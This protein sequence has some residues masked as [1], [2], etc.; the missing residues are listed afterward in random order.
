MSAV[1]SNPSRREFL[2]AAA[3]AG[4]GLLIGFSMPGRRL[5]AAEPGSAPFHPNAFIR[6]AADDSV[7]LIVSMAEMGQGVLTSLPQLLAEELE[8]DWHRVRVE[9]APVDPA[10]N[11]PI[12]GLQ[13]TGGSTS[14]RAFWDP[15]RRAGASARE[16][17]IT[18]AATSWGVD[19][20]T[21]HAREGAV[22][23]A[24]GKQLSYG[25]LAARASQLPVPTDVALKDPKDFKILGRPLQ[26]L[27]SPGKV[28][29]SAR[30]GL[31]VR[32][33]GLLTAVIARP[34]A[35]GAKVTGFDASRAKAVSGVKHVV[36]V[37]SGVAVVAD[38]FWAAK[39]GRDALDVQWDLGASS[40]LSSKGI[41]EA[42]L[43]RLKTSGLVAR[44][45]G[46]VTTASPASTLEAIYE[47]PY[48]AHACM[49]PMNATAAVT[50]AGVDVWAPTQASGVNRAVVAKLTGVPPER[51]NV[52]TTLLGGGFG[53]RF[54]QDFVIAA[55]QVSKAVGAP[56]KVVYTR[57]D[58]MRGLHYRPASV[59]RI[60]GGLD[61]AGK[62]ALL[63]ARVACPSVMQASGMGPPTG[64][65]E[66]AVEGLHEWPYA[67]PHVR[68]E[69]A[70]HE[71]GVGVWFWRSVGNSQNAFFAETF[72]DELAHAAKQD[73]FAYRREL[74]GQHPRHRAVLELA[75]SKAGWGSPLPKGRARGIAVSESFKSYVAEVVEVS[76]R[77]DG[78][79]RV[80]RVVCAVDCGMTVNPGI[81]RRQVQSA[82]I[83]GL[84]AALHGEITLQ[85]GRVQ[86]KNF[87]D[88][89]VVRID[90]APPIE[91]HLVASNEKPTG[92]GEPGTP[93]IAPALGNALFALTGKRVRRL[94]FKSGDFAA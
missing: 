12:F 31:D 72:I 47:A 57:E 53:R 15:L 55:V 52:T 36:Q 44:N 46:D 29:G 20:S 86:Q 58:D 10:Y 26:R 41:H 28:N 1:P 19:R 59:V 94:P 78:T 39:T 4:G 68:V 73:P 66:T 71:P 81:V 34:P 25:A 35:I 69:W 93:P 77:P 5:A 67:T 37:E 49:E 83:F 18:A 21:C 7:T 23:H 91:V 89:P 85:G 33:P 6:I 70:Q 65:D 2:Q 56:V 60:R 63:D 16:M 61:A 50:D 92:I 76:L 9:Q 54:A 22:H 79:P 45:D 84:S 8:A 64:L 30:F 40:G 75:A 38:G 90:E 24:S 62:P 88:Y 13:G 80:H 3:V 48:L 32:M 43:E 42:L 14:V 27:D 51:V 74:L 82:V 11:N 17:L 87:D